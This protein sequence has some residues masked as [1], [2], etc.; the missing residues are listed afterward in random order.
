MKNYFVKLEQHDIL[1][2]T[3]FKSFIVSASSTYEAV[4]SIVE[5]F[6]SGW[7][8]NRY[9]VKVETLHSINQRPGIAELTFI[10]PFFNKTTGVYDITLYVSEI[11]VPCFQVE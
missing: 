2:E 7:P 10:Y 1:D 5:M 8:K 4:K 6:F 11:V 9:E 3:T